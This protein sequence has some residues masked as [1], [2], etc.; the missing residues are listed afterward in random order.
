MSGKLAA[1]YIAGIMI[2]RFCITTIARQRRILNVLAL[3]VVNIIISGR[4]GLAVNM[5]DNVGVDYSKLVCR[6]ATNKV[7]RR[8][9]I[10]RIVRP[11]I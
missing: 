1:V 6:G 3:V 7:R 11:L 8:C 10:S 4:A 2:P 5:E 9:S